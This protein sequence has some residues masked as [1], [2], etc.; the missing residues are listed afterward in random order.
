MHLLVDDAGHGLGTRDLEL[1]AFTPHLLDE[2]GEVELAAPAHEELVRAVG[3]LHAQRHVRLQLALEPVP[4]HAGCRVL[5]LPARERRRVDAERHPHGG[6]LHLHARQGFLRRRGR[7]GVPDADAAQAGERHDLSGGGRFDRMPREVAESEQALHAV[8]GR[9]VVLPKQHDLLVLGDAPTRHA[10][11]RDLS[12][13]VVVVERSNEH[14]Q[15]RVRVGDG[16]RHALDDSVEQR[17]HVL[18][19]VGHLG[20]RVP[21]AR[22]G[23][24][25]REVQLVRVGSQF[26][27]EVLHC[28]QGGGSVRRGAVDLVD[29][30][31]GTQP[32]LERDAQHVARLRHRPFNR[33]D[34]EQAT[35]GHVHDAL[36]FAAEVGVA[37]GVDDVDRDVAVPDAR[38]LGEDGDSPFPLLRVRVHDQVVYLLVRAEDAAV[39][40]HGVNQ[41][42]LAVVD[43]GDDSDVAEVGLGCCRHVPSSA[44]HTSAPAGAGAALWGVTCAL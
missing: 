5:P 13:V 42:C 1:D 17:P 11:H 33:V 15:R 20:E 38:V 18:R 30:E 4:Q 19:R 25:H 14:L 27:E 9:A 43:V 8:R 40:E 16:R 7:D 24:Q 10:P 3:A 12:E 39:T 44:V 26:Q 6:V 23:V 32:L 36:D 31:D 29:D 21:V 22:R 28:R 34:D 37:R 2:D 35:V 41:A